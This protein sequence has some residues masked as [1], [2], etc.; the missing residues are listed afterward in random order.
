MEQANHQFEDFLMSVDEAHKDFVLAVHERLLQEGCKCKVGSSKTNLFSVKYTQ[1]RRGIFN[2]ALRKRG[3]KSSVYASNFAQY[4]EVLDS[5]PESMV[6]QI[7]KTSDCKN[8][9]GPPTCW[10]GCVGY[11]IPIR[12]ARYPKCKFG[13][14]QFDV[15]AESI[16]FLHTLLD[17]ELKAR[18]AA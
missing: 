1:G 14:F 8:M 6:A 17:S 18:Q 5:L 4:P 2:F 9:S 3:M 12:D 13:C 7:A 10:E 16:P 15:N 11:D